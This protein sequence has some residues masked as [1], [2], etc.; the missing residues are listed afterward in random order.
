[1]LSNVGSYQRLIKKLLY[2]TITRPNI[3]YDVKNLT[4]YLQ[5]PKKSHMEVVLRIIKYIKLQL[6]LGIL[7]S[8]NQVQDVTAFCNVDWAACSHTIRSVIDFLI[9]WEF[10]WYLRNK[11]KLLFPEALLYQGTTL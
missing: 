3:A 1:M 5:E 2:L 8:S 10:L 4:Q 9:N 6:D 11:K 7:M